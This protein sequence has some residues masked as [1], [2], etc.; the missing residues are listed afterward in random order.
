MGDCQLTRIRLEAK[1][2]DPSQ[3]SMFLTE[4]IGEFR[5]R[6]GG[7]WELEDPGVQTMSAVTP[8]VDKDGTWGRATIRRKT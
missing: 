8:G 4:M 3:V 5:T 6:E 7:E 1:G 2:P